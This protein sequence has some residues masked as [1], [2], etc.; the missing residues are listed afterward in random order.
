MVR[1]LDRPQYQEFPETA[2][3]AYPVFY[4]TYSRRVDGQRETWQQ[5]GDRVVR[6]LKKLGKLSDDECDLLRRMHRNIQSLPSGRWLWVG[7]TEWL[8]N[9]AN[10]SGAYNCTSTNVTDWRA[11]GLMMDLAMMGCGTGAV[12]EPDYIEQ[13]PPIR[14]SLTVTVEGTQGDIPA[15]ERQEETTVAIAGNDVTVVV[16]D[17]RQGWVKSYQTILELSSA[18]T[19][20]GTV[21]ITIDIRHIRPTGEILKGFGGVANPVKVP[22][23]YHKL[24]KILNKAVGRQLTSVE[25]CLLIDQ[26]AVVVVAGNVRRSAGMRQF[27]SEDADGAATA[28]TVALT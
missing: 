19:F 13:L 20:D 7:G 24:V 16:G 17:S 23:M 9:P 18:D 15:E 1:E 26:A 4:R 5:V 14:N 6:G 21:N 10:F 8:E 28:L 2:P 22:D 25:C 12:L 27:S 11:F 3:T